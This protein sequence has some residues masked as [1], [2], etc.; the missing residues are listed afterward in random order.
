[1][2]VARPGSG[3]GTPSRVT[4]AEHFVHGFLRRLPAGWEPTDVQR[5]AYREH[6]RRVGK[7]DGWELPRGYTFVTAHSRRR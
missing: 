6:C 1:V 7:A 3:G 5:A 4:G 2:V